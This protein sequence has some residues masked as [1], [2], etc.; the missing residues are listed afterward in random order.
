MPTVRTRA[1]ELAYD[2]LGTGAP[3]LLV[4]SAA[5]DRR[6]WDSI[7]PELARRH[8]TVAVD[9]P[10]HGESPAPLPSWQPSAA[11]VADLVEDVVDGLNLGPTSVLGSSVGGFAAA[12]L[13]IRR[14]EAVR[15][16][17]LV[18]HGGFGSY[19]FGVR[20][21]CR[22]MGVPALLRLAYPGFARGYLRASSA[23]D[24]EVLRVARQL[25]RRPERAEVVAGL[26]RSF[27]GPEHS[28]ESR[29]AEITAPT[30]IVWGNRDPV[31]PISAGRRAAELIPGARFVSMDTGHLPFSSD[32]AG[33]LAHVLP[34]LAAVPTG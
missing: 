21:F 10:A 5:H 27:P 22:A 2:E 25:R 1:G 3:L 29:A 6:D 8:R 34:F 24:R 14:P 12:R 23:H 4:H 31:I 16:L 20:L 11:G 30:L 19:P 7:R 28:L 32:P 18:D 9:L 17:I 15:A 13:A 26:W 33:F